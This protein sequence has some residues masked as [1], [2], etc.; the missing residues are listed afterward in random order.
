MVPN[1]ATSG[2]VTVTVAGV[3]S[4]PVQFSVLEA[5]TVTG[6]SPNAG[7]VGGSV[8]ITGT[9]FGS[10]QSN[11]TVNFY[12]AT[13]TSFIS[14]SDTQIVV[15]AP[16]YIGT[17]PVSV[18]VAGM[19]VSGPTFILSRSSQLTDSLGNVSNYSAIDM[20]GEWKP[21]SEDGS[22]CSS[23]SDRGT[24]ISTYDSKGNV[25]TRTDPAGHTTTYTYDSSYDVLSESVQ[26]N[27]TTTAT[28][29]Y[30]YNSF[31][32]VLTVTDPLGHVTTNTYDS[33]G[34]LLTVTSPAPNSSTAASVTY[35]CLQLAR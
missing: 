30:T 34:N 35:I 21:V 2:P 13:A 24:I 15:V 11:S 33:H 1:N 26:L 25:L 9:G 32:E 31:G 14:W 7:P 28:T 3:T 6:I 29:S 19:N 18:T 5:T 23:C 4:N 27:G 22:G 10:T 12:G 16:P 20:G 8:A 17:G